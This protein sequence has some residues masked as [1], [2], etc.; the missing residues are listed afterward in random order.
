MLFKPISVTGNICDL[1]EDLLVEDI[2]IAIRDN[3]QLL[4]PWGA[5]QKLSIQEVEE[6]IRGLAIASSSRQSQESRTVDANATLPSTNS[7]Q[8]DVHIQQKAQVLPESYGDEQDRAGQQ[9][10]ATG[11]SPGS[12]AK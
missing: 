6:D 7:T 2:R 12:S 11:D 10:E 5:R 4:E 3:P 8:V 9:Q 1:E